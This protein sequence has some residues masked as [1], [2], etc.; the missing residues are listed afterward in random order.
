MCNLK[1]SHYY[2]T[3]S[4][5][6]EKRFKIPTCDIFDFVCGCDETVVPED[7]G[8]EMVKVR[9]EDVEGLVR[10]LRGISLL[11]GQTAYV[12]EAMEKRLK[13]ALKA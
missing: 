13:K 12:A 11:P 5:R 4:C 3:V 2:V 1:H 8:K 10:L 9:R 7:Y 6:H